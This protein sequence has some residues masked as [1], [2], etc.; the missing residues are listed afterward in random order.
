MYPIKFIVLLSV[1][2]LIYILAGINL[3]SILLKR[4]IE[5][6]ES[7]LLGLAVMYTFQLFLSLFPAAHSFIMTGIFLI[8]NIVIFAIR[9]KAKP[10]INH[11]PFRSGHLQILSFILM[12]SVILYY[13]FAL[14]I[15]PLHGFDGLMIY[16]SRARII[17]RGTIT[18]LMDSGVFTAHNKYPLMLSLNEYFSC[19]LNMR[20]D[21]NFTS[22]PFIMYIIAFAGTV[23]H[24]FRRRII[25]GMLLIAIFFITPIFMMSDAGIVY[26]YADFLLALFFFSAFV[27]MY[28]G[29]I[30]KCIFV[31]SMLPLIKNEGWVLFIVV[32][33][34]AAFTNRKQIQDQFRNFPSLFTLITVNL[35]SWL[36]VR[37]FLTSYIEEITLSA[38]LCNIMSIR[39]IFTVIWGF[40]ITAADPRIWGFSIIIP[41][42][43]IVLK[44]RYCKR[45]YIFILYTLIPVTAYVIIS[46][47]IPG[48]FYTTIND[49]SYRLLSHIFPIVFFFGLHSFVDSEGI[50]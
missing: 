36:I 37:Y 11:C 12:A 39:N 17:Y 44:K 47:L 15:T 10:Y 5:L 48:N 23:V 41:L 40:I 8:I 29:D 34:H 7:I 49:I 45:N 33:V 21:Y 24:F 14:Y 50:T 43:L 26:Q 46:S 6:Y 31:A 2:L 35:I 32:F 30:P 1:Q 4:H 3:G 9:T 42:L 13:A 27:S 16:G 38:L 22:I 20:F 28:E 19:L 25:V 18:N